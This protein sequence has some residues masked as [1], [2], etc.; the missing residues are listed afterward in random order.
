MRR[1]KTYACRMAAY[2]MA[3][4][5]GLGSGGL[6]AIPP[7]EA[8]ASPEFAYPPEKW[9][10]LRDDVMEY[11]ELADLVHEYNATVI[12]NRLEYDEYRGKSR[13]D[14]KNAY[15][16]LA[17]S[18]YQASDDLL[19]SVNEDD[20]GYG[21]VAAQAALSRVQAEQ[22]QDL[23]DAQNE[24]GAIKKLEYEREEAA[25]VQQAQTKMISYW[26]KEEARPSLEAAYALARSQYEAAAIRAGAGMLSQTEL[27]AAEE[28]A[29]S[30]KAAL[31]TNEKEQD[32]LRR[33]LCVMTGWAHDA[34]PEIQSVPIP[35][36]EELNAVRPEEDLNRAVQAN[37]VQR[38]NEGR[39]KYT[40]TAGNQREIMEKKVAAGAAK[41][42]ADVAAKYQLLSQAGEDYEQ[43]AQ[44]YEL[45]ERQAEAAGLRQ[46]LGMI[47]A[48]Q[49]E[50][51]RAGLAQKQ[52]ALRQAGLSL[53]Q[54]LEDYRWAVNGLAQAE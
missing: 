39:L 1:R 18:M 33:E 27:L 12:N 54:A 11:E 49:Y 43:A 36:K 21:R 41:I 47:S 23:A 13:D 6:F 30:A 14:L 31:L 52:A 34:S 50:G 4:G 22:N 46:G 38:A 42:K 3:A 2:C 20:P 37:F 25:L 35:G 51:Q 7:L 8:I 17:D 44:E 28:R 29:E 19:D 10:A 15:Q 53:R 48:N 24:D 32:A 45:T 16:N 5:L 40:S 26:Q 9:A